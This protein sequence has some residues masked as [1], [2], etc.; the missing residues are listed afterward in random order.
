MISERSLLTNDIGLKRL[1]LVKD[2]PDDGPD[3]IRRNLEALLH[4]QLRSQ[5]ATQRINHQHNI[6]ANNVAVYQAVMGQANA[7]HLPQ[8]PGPPPRGPVAGR[9]AVQPRQLPP[10]P[11]PPAAPRR[12]DR[13]RRA[14]QM[15]Y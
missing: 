11:P 3:P 9:G 15:W 8:Q 5:Q 4:E 1:V 14:N 13:D 10:P 6:I 12:G 7:N 2:K